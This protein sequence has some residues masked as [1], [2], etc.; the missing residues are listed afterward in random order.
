MIL[1]TA[2]VAGILSG[3]A[4]ASANTL[5]ETITGFGNTTTAAWT[6]YM[7]KSDKYFTDRRNQGYTCEGYAPTLLTNGPYIEVKTGLAY[8]FVYRSDIYCTY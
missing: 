6:D 5:H 8:N 3:Q 1:A 2:V 7:T 4:T